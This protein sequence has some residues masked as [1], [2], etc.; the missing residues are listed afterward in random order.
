MPNTTDQHSWY[1]PVDGDRDYEDTFETFF[2]QLDNDV[3]IRDTDTNKNN[4]DPKVGAKYVAT[5]T[6]DVYIGDGDSWNHLVS[7][8]KDPTFESVSTDKLNISEPSGQTDVASISPQGR[9]ISN[10]EFSLADDASE[11]ISESHFN[12]QATLLFVVNKSDNVAALFSAAFN[13]VTKMQGQGWEAADTDGEN[14]VFVNANDK[15]VVKNRTGA[16]KSYSS[17][18][19]NINGNL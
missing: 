19:L 1:Y 13:N 3:E 8:G 14:C 4:Y 10:G 6:E 12:R 2:E 5:D 16:N 18:A 17:F 7:T 15:L 9:I 11:I